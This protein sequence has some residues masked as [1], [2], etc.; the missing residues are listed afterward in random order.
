MIPSDPPAADR[1]GARAERDLYEAFRDRL[2]DDFFVYHRLHYI[3]DRSRTEGEADF[4]VLHPARGMLVVECKGEGVARDGEGRWWRVRRGGARSPLEES[5]VEQAERT[6]WELVEALTPRCRKA[7]PERREFPL[8]YGHAVAFPRADADALNL[9]LDQPR[10]L[11]FDAN[12]LD[13]VAEKV[14]GAM[15]LWRDKAGRAAPAPL[16]P[17]ELKRMRKQALHPVLEI[18]ET[19][20][21]DIRADS[22]RMHRLT[23]EQLATV[24][25]FLNNPRLKVRGGAGT[26][27]TVLALEA[28]R[29]F[30]E[31]GK[32]VLLVCFNKTLGEYLRA[33]V[34]S[35]EMA[36]GAGTVSATSFHKLCGLAHRR[37]H[38][39]APL[40]VP[41][42]REDEIRFWRDGAPYI[43]LEGLAEGAIPKVDAVVIDEGQDFAPT[44][45]EVLEEALADKA[46]GR[47]LAFYDPSQE[48]FGRGCHVPEWPEY[49]LTY[50]FRNT[51]KIAE[52]VRE[53]GRV[54][55]LS[56]ESCPVGE[57]PEEHEQKSAGTARA[58]IE[59]LVRD[60]VEKDRVAVEGIAVLTPHTREN[61]CLRGVAEIAGIAIAEK[62]FDRAGKLLHATVGA[63]KGL[64]SDVIIYADVDPDDPLCGRNARY[65]AASR[66][67]HRLYVYAKGNWRD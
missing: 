11:I 49:A 44:W 39:N 46:Q 21:A 6:K 52:V 24:R 59:R 16:E 45:W 13:H 63:F 53:L 28:A 22:R 14:V 5:P 55:M 7:L 38:D 50:N 32:N 19:L 35:W 58:A 1:P 33:S 2:G 62:P 25:G 57:P 34:D 43:L 37:L 67:R 42:E 61:S 40:D 65:V 56:F 31:S 8:V 15:K 66:A 10:G 30:A 48:I 23:V 17:W 47:T 60:L 29:R 4:L 26:G 54:E 9:P 20:G 12:D 36:E 3:D 18:V 41:K 27:K 64:E 51:R